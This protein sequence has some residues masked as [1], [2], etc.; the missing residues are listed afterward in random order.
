MPD[1]AG[2]AA[3]CRRLSDR[4]AEALGDPEQPQPDPPFCIDCGNGRMLGVDWQLRGDLA[5]F[6]MLLL[7]LACLVTLILTRGPLLWSL[8]GLTALATMYFVWH[9]GRLRTAGAHWLQQAQVCPAAVVMAH[10]SLFEPGS[11]TMPGAMLVSFAAEPDAD[12]LQ[13]AAR[14]VFALLRDRAPPPRL[15]PLREWLVASTRRQHYDRLRVPRELAGDDHTFLI[16]L[17]LDRELMPHGYLDR[18]LWFVLARPD[19]NESVE[20]LPYQYWW[21]EGLDEGNPRRADARGS[22]TA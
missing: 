7:V 15:Q 10:H 1:P 22:A 14:L 21:H 4:H 19:R 6:A 2:L 16:G 5:L 3:I 9:R 8:A 13:A 17:R 18:K 11:S 20:L 12:R